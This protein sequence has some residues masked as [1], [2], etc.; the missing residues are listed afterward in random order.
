MPCPVLLVPREWLGG[1]WGKDNYPSVLEALG[2]EPTTV[3]VF[4]ANA[5]SFLEYVIMYRPK[6]M[7]V[8]VQRV[9]L[10]HHEVSKLARDFSWRVTVHQQAVKAKK[11]DRLI[12]REDMTRCM[13]VCR[14][15]IPSL[16]DEV[17]AASLDNFVPRFRFFGYLAAYLASIYGHRSCVL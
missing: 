7:R 5:K 12:S 17:E 9:R 14:T 2:K 8:S 1:G 10:L 6:A 4:L 13:E 11:L 16:L 15:R 3:I